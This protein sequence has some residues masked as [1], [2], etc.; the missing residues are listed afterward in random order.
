MDCRPPATAAAAG[1]EATGA[2]AAVAVVVA[3][4][5]GEEVVVREWGSTGF[6]L[7]PPRTE[8]RLRISRR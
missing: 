4:V 8:R 1:K 3:V 6:A 5:A 2:V 7:R